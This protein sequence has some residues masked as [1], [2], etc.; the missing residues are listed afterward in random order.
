MKVL[1]LIFATTVLVVKAG[2]VDVLNEV[3]DWSAFKVTI[4]SKNFCHS[5]D[6]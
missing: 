3:D 4:F 6:Q 5:V 2:L 1:V